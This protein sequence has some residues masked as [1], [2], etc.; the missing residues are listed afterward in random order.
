MSE[1]PLVSIV[2]PSFN[3]G[4]FIEE[5]IRSVLD[6]D[7]PNIEYLVMDGGS[8]D[9]TLDI[10]KRYEGRL[11][12]VSEP[13]R[14]QTDAVNKGF[15]SSRGSIFTFLNADDTL[16][17]GAVTAAVQA[18]ADHPEAGVVYGDAW[19]I[20]EDGSRTAPYPV[21]PFDAKKFERR[22]FICQ[23][24]AFIRREVY[25]SSGMLDPERHN[26]LDYDLWIRI[27][28]RYPMKKI[29]KFLANSRI[30]EGSKTVYQMGPAM[31]A[32]IEVLRHYYGY[33]P[34]NWLYG[35]CHYR[36]TGQP[37]AIER[38]QPSALSACLSIAF[39]ARYNWRYP[40]RYCRDII[41]TAKEGVASARRE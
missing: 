8:S 17:P 16:L 23:P 36:L 6:Q 2:T 38:P 28:Q 41:S 1:Q 24:A 22:C 21:E 26:A 12:Y 32:A 15:Q 9:G 14:G 37:L 20:A 33:V 18:F 34:Y 10:L 19:F 13:D 4:G 7:Y 31:L 30:H 39:G 5:T 35:Y 11:K 25:S 29:D 27:A 3:M 40:L